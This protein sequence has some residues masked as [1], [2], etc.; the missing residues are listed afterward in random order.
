MTALRQKMIEDMQLHS[1][2]ERTQ[3]SYLRAVRQL[4][5]YFNKPPDQISEEELRQYSKVPTVATIPQES[6]RS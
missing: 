2:S 5:A 1:F 4:A 3:D 6:L